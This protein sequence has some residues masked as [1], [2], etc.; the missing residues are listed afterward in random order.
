MVP[1]ALAGWAALVP[2]AIGNGVF[3][4][5]VLV[6]RFGDR[7]GHV[8][9]TFMLSAFL[10]LFAAVFL[11]IVPDEQALRDLLTVSFTWVIATVLFEFVFGH[12]VMGAPWERLLADYNISKGRIWSLVLLSEFVAP[13]MM[14]RLF[15]L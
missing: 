15:G 11:W 12:F 14:G 3:R 1:Y 13:I 10:F 7:A 5:A 9:S 4:Q 2:F 6:P 8:A